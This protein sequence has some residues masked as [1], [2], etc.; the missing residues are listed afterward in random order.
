MSHLGSISLFRQDYHVRFWHGE[1][2]IYDGGNVIVNDVHKG[3]EFDVVENDNNIKDKYEDTEVEDDDEEGDH[4][5]KMMEGVI[6]AN[7]LVFLSAWPRHLGN[8]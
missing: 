3:C 5:E 7:G 6:L 8:R 2:G 4:I 1:E